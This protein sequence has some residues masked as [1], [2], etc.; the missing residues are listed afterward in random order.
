[1]AMW[2]LGKIMSEATTRAGYRSDITSSDVS[3]MANQA[4]FQVAQ[5]ADH[6]LLEVAAYTSI[7]SGESRVLLP[8]D[9]NEPI[10]L[11]Y[12]TGGTASSGLTIRRTSVE[13]ADAR[14]FSPQ[15]KPEEYIQYANWLELYPSPNSSWSVLF[16]Y[17]AYPT[18]MAS[19]DAIPSVDTEWA[20]AIMYLT[21][22]LVQ[23]RV[24]NKQEGAVARGLYE[25]YV[26]SLKDTIA[27]RQAERGDDRIQLVHRKNRSRSRR[28]AYLNDD[29]WYRF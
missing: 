23:E 26:S 20:Q 7:L 15:G 21:E 11:S 16:R 2:T 19:L 12:L 24:G 27:K 18:Q 28:E 14:G 1:M 3:F 10:L 4:Y 17:K 22:A 13:R 29:I 9:L 5:E 25:G 6:A 8:D